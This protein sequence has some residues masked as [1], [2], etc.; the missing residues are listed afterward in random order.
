MFQ[1][2]PRAAFP[3]NV[4]KVIYVNTRRPSRACAGMRDRL[5]PPAR[6][7]ERNADLPV[8]LNWAHMC[9]HSM[10]DKIRIAR[11]AARRTSPV[12]GDLDTLR[13]ALQTVNLHPQADL[14]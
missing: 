11:T 1:R 9:A 13:I 6:R 10:R 7:I 3:D 14:P 12:R 2:K 8:I 5:S 4:L